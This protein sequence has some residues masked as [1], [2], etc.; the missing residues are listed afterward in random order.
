MMIHPVILSGGSG[1]RLWPLSR[2]SFPKQLHQLIGRHSLLQETALRVS[3]LAPPLVVC[4]N[5][6]RFIVGEQ[7]RGIGVTPSRIV[8]EP[9]GRNTAPAAAVAALILAETDADARMLVLPSDHHIRDGEAFGRAIEAAATVPGAP[10]VCFGVQPDRPYTGYGYIGRGGPVGAN[11]ALVARFVEKPDAETAQKYLASGDYYWNAGIFLFPVTRYLEELGRVR[12][13]MLEQCRAAVAET[14]DDLEF[15]RLDEEAF[16]AVDGES[17]DYAVME[18]TDDAAMVVLD[19]GWSDIG[20]WSSLHAESGTDEAGNAIVGD[21]AA[22]DCSNSYLRSEKSLVAAIGLEN[23]IVVVSE[24]AVLV[25]D[26]SR[27]QMVGDVVKDLVTKQR[28]EAT[29]AVREWRPWGSFETIG[30]GS[31]YHVKQVVVEAGESLS[32][33]M[34]HRRSEHWVVVQG[35]AEVTRGDDTFLLREGESTFIPA[36]TRHRLANRGELP[37]RIVEIQVGSYFG[38]DDIV[39]FSDD[40]G[41]IAKPGP[42]A[43]EDD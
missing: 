31:R 10:M 24:D 7:L 19:A 23:M 21:V 25:A 22:I 4:N 13:K 32:L 43:G 3:G 34:H 28:R 14:W 40:Y 33:Q 15:T 27:D 36:G 30:E 2:E 12:P 20:S 17:I 8:L 38:E 16:A 1:T 6:H 26:R 35:T 29:Q 11:A 9:V 18:N 37:V 41:R 39:R 5:E 42:K